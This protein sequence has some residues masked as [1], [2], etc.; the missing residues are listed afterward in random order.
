[1]HPVTRHLMELSPPCSVFSMKR[2]PC[3]GAST[4]A[5]DIY[6]LK[7]FSIGNPSLS[8]FIAVCILISKLYF[9]IKKWKNTTLMS[10]YTQRWNNNRGILRGL[11]TVAHVV[12]ECK[13]GYC[14]SLRF[15]IIIQNTKLYLI[16]P[17]P[18]WGHWLLGIEYI[19]IILLLQV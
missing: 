1:M 6:T 3:D 11:D 17:S 15:M 13:W 14:Q 4:N 19:I 18:E 5:Q 7:N 8:N 10:K 12:S 2:R 9:S 16:H